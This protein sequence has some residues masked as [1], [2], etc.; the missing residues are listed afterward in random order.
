MQITIEYANNEVKTIGLCEKDYF[1]LVNNLRIF[2][3]YTIVYGKYV[4]D[5]YNLDDI[6]TIKQGLNT[7]YCNK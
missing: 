1:E 2:N 6:S 7:I 3:I 4:C 5:S